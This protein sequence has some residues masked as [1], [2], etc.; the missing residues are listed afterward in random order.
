MKKHIKDERTELNYTLIGDYY[1]PD[2]TAEDKMYNIGIWGER[3]REY[4]KN[5][6][7]SLYHYLQTTLTLLQHLENTE[8]EAQN[9]YDNLIRQFAEKENVSEQLKLENQFLWV[10][11]MKSIA[12]RAREIVFDEIIYR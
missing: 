3:R 5:H 12:M 1:I 10:K 8:I 6:R 2:I 11:K 4:L 7:K 9:L